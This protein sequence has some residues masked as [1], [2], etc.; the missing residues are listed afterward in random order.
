MIVL[1]SRN[2]QQHVTTCEKTMILNISEAAK[3]VNVA[4]STLYNMRKTGTLSF[5]QSYDGKPGVEES[6]LA[7]VFSSCFEVDMKIQPNTV[8]DSQTTDHLTHKV[9]YLQQLLDEQKD[10]QLT[11]LKTQLAQAEHR[12]N[13]LIKIT[14]VQSNQLLLADDIRKES[15]IQKLF[16][17]KNKI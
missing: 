13:D 14:G 7:R 16:N 10:K 17:L 12:I 4:R 1:S 15:W 5:T 3:R 9:A 8:L 2:R 6:E 11:E